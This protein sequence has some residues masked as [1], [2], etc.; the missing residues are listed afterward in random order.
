MSWKPE[1]RGGGNDCRNSQPKAVTGDNW[2]D[3]ANPQAGLHSFIL[4]NELQ[5]EAAS[6]TWLDICLLPVGSSEV[7]VIE[8]KTYRNFSSLLCGGHS[9]LI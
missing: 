8:S 6:S 9:V 4:A 3:F 7:S 5:N 2:A 1:T